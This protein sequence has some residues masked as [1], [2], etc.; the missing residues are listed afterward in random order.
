M[1]VL[2]QPLGAGS[3][4]IRQA[5][6][7]ST[8]T[9]TGTGYRAVLA[10][11]RVRRLLAAF[12]ASYLGDGMSAVAV[13]WLA[14]AL[15]PGPH[16]GLLV[17]AAIAAYTLP[18]VLG[19]AAFGRWLRP[20][21]ARRLLIADSVLRAVLLGCVPLAWAAGV[22][23]PGLYVAL[24]AASSLLRSWGQAGKFTILAEL[25]PERQ[26]LSV[27]ALVSTLGFSTIVVGPAVAGVLSAG[28][29]PAWVLGL[30]ALSFAALAA[31]VAATR[32]PPRAAD[33]AGP[34][35]TG[36]RWLLRAR[37]Q[38]FA[39]LVLTWLFDLLYGPVEV[40]LPLHVT[41]DLAAGS[42]LL[43]LYWTAFG[44]GSVAGGLL[45]GVLRRLPRWPVTVGIVGGWGLALLPFGLGAPAAVTVACFGLG[46]L[47]FGPF[48]ALSMTLVQDETP[49][50][51]LASVLAL[52]S[53]ALM[54]AAP[55][56][57][58]LGGPL[59]TAFGPR[60]VLAGS[61]VATVALA[62]VSLV[63]VLRIRGSAEGDAAGG[64]RLS[65]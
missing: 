28:I 22:L 52:R 36:V 33:T 35:A 1:G 15:A 62:A 21:S 65:P 60:P 23:S 63:A 46:G 37:P 55:V 11:R 49:P 13:A 17:G 19:V 54:T 64:G 41:T 12:A 43:G 38:L 29:G 42:A 30:D 24:L 56:G 59:V 4:K 58:A 18:A 51:Q 20:V 61:G 32:V 8:D 7:V 6:A 31:V 34:V 10:D 48:N 47:I 14:I 40:A 3:A 2:K 53:A 50:R 9:A 39:L 57:A 5:G 16:A 44:V 45:T 25:V 26:R 27:N